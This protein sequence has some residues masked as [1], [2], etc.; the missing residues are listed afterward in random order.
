MRC[1]DIAALKFSS[2]NW[3]RELIMITQQKT[4][5]T[6]ELKLPTRCGN[7]IYEYVLN[8]RPKTDTREIFVRSIPPYSGLQARTLTE[9]AENVA[10]AANVR[11][12]PGNRRGFHLYRHRLATSLLENDIPNVVISKM[13]GHNS[14]ESLEIYLGADFTH[15]KE[16]ALSIEK[17]PVDLRGVMR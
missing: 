10:R 1:C 3:E 6:Q 11:Q 14:P 17:F 13:L 16:C 8:E 2:I 12:N 9:I 4:D 15:L 7:A 5:S